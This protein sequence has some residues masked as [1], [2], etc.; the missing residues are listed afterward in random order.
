[1]GRVLNAQIDASKGTDHEGRFA[2]AISLATV[3]SIGQGWVSRVEGSTKLLKM[4]DLERPC[5]SPDDPKKRYFQ[6]K[7][8]LLVNLVDKKCAPPAP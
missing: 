7:D 5:T 1:M 2:A 3:R 6:A 4:T 8:I